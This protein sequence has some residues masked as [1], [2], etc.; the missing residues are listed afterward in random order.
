MNKNIFVSILELKKNNQTIYKVTKRVP[1][2][3]V[4]ETK[5]FKSKIEALK[6]LAEWLDY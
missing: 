5:V 6:Q 4:S 1:I 2:M 3:F